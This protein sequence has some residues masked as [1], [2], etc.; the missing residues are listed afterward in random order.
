MVGSR[1]IFLTTI[2]H[3]IEIQE[4]SAQKIRFVLSGNVAGMLVITFFGELK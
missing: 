4:I 2:L 3:V 1:K